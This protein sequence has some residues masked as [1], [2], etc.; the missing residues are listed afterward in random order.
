MDGATWLGMER[1]G[2][3]A[4]RLPVTDAVRSGARA[5]FG[6]CATAASIVAAS[7]CTTQPVVFASS[8]FGVLAKVG[9]TMDVSA[10]TISTGRTMTH[11]E[12]EGSVDGEHSFLCRVTAGERPDP[13]AEGQWIEPPV[14][15]QPDACDAFAHPVHDGT[16]ASRFEW[17]LAGTSDGTPTSRW[18]VR[19]VDDLDPLIA[20]TI[21]ADYVTYGIGRAVGESIGGLSID[22]VV[23]VG[24]LNPTT[25]PTTWYLLEIAPEVA[26]DGIGSGAARVYADDELVVSG[27]QSIVVLPWDWRLPTERD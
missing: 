7:A 24:R 15:P 22:N 5:L 10:R 23:R 18:W 8:H 20:A 16:W 13:P 14:V 26:V 4:W 25:K 12:I 19:P 21:V 27:S 11:L 17:R 9:S 2:D 3:A 1:T 6:G